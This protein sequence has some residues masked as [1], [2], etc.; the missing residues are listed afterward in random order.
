LVLREK[1]IPKFDQL[2]DEIFGSLLLAISINPKITHVEGPILENA[3]RKSA[4]MAA[5]LNLIFEML[6]AIGNLTGVL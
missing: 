4:L 5:C 2:I 6:C 1:P 3:S